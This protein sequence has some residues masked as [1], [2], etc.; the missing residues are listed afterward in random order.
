MAGDRL[1]EAARRASERRG[2]E[3]AARRSEGSERDDD[4]VPPSGP[5]PSRRLLGWLGGDVPCELCARRAQAGTAAA[6][7][8]A[9]TSCQFLAATWVVITV[10]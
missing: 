7:D 8:V 10:G 9:R 1:S 6:L 2:R 4:A 3:P 5:P